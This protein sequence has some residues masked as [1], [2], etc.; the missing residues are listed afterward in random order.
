M[1][2][3]IFA[4]LGTAMGASAATAA[5]VGTSTALSLAGAG[6]SAVGAYNTAKGQRQALEYQGQ[7]ND[8]NAKVAEFQAQDAEAR[9]QKESQIA[10]QRASA[11]QGAQRASLAARGL[12]LSTG[13]PLSLMQDT[14]YFGAVD[15]ATIKDNTAKEAWSIRARKDDY[16]ATA[17]MQRTGAGNIN[18]GLSLATSLVNSGASVSSAWYRYKGAD[19]R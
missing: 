14:E 15:Q 1:C 18:P 13:T 5:A 16:T 2:I 7:V 6:M 3:P 19:V 8:R 4:A 9:G 17:A 11:M 10:R 12:D